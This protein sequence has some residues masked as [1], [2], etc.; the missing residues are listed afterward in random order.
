M[1]GVG[2]RRHSLGLSPIRCAPGLCDAAEHESERGVPRS[3][4]TEENENTDSV[5]IRRWQD[6][7]A[8]GSVTCAGGSGLGEQ[9]R[10]AR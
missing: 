5:N 2:C 7:K 4:Q 1:P 8:P 10:V 6:C 9:G 3:R